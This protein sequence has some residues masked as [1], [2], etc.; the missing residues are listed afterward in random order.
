[1]LRLQLI[2]GMNVW[3]DDQ[4]AE[5]PVSRRAWAL[6]AWLAL[7]PGL[8]ARATVAATFWPDVLDSSARASLRSALWSLRQSLGERS[9]DYLHLSRENLGLKH[10]AQIWVDT[11]AV[12]ELEAAGR[13]ADAVE[14]GYG[15]LLA[16]FDDEWVIEARDAYRPK[17]TGLL[18]ILASRAEEGGNRATAV[19]LTRRQI[20]LDPM[21]EEPL[22]RLMR[23]LAASGDRAAAMTAYNRFRNKL[24]RE[25]RIVPSPE[26]RLLAD[27]LQ[28]R[29]AEIREPVKAAPYD[30]PLIGR[31]HEYAKL[32]AA[33]QDARG[34]KSVVATIS[35]EPGIGK[36]RLATELLNLARADGAMVAG[37][38]AVDLGATAPF[39]MWAELIGGLASSLD[40]PPLDSVW[41]SALAPLAPDFESRLGRQPVVASRTSPELERTRLYEATVGMLLWA[42][43]NQPIVLLMEDIHTADVATLDLIGYVCRR[44]ARVP[45]LMILTR[46]PLPHR[47]QVDALEQSLRAQR[48]LTTEIL[49]G[50]LTSEHAAHLVREVA[51]LPDV[52]VDQVVTAAD[53]NALLA[54]EWAAALARGENSPP[55][56]LRAAVR[57][58]LAPLHGDALELALFAAISGRSLDREEVLSLPLRSPQDAMAAAS[59]CSLLTTSRGRVGYRHALLREAAYVDLS[60]PVCERLHGQ[61]G[62]LLAS[63]NP[64]LAAEAARHLR[65]A[66]RD[67][68]AVAQLIR[69]AD[70]ARAVAALPE[71]A[72]ILTEALELEPHN[73]SIMIDLAEVEALRGEESASS[74]LFERALTC[75]TDPTKLAEAWV[76]RA[77]WYGAA[78]C[79]PRNALDAA[80]RAVEVM[81]GNGVDAPELRIEALALWSWAESVAGDVEMADTL[82]QQVHA[83]LGKNR[84]SDA[85]IPAIGHARAFALLRRGK[86][87]ESYPPEIASAEASKRLGRPDL[88]YGAWANA[89]C[90][91]SCAGE[92]ERALEFV[93]RGLA[94]VADRGLDSLEF[95]LL[96]GRSHVLARLGHHDEA[97][98]AADRQRA[99]AE[100]LNSPL[101]LAVVDHDAG[102][103]ALQLGEPVEAARMLGAALDHGATVSRPIARLSRAEALVATGR[104][105]EAEEE[106]RLTA[107]EPVGPGDMPEALVPRLTWLQGLIARGRGDGSLARSRLQ[108]AAAGWRRVL[109]RAATG[110][111]FVATLADFGRPPVVGMVEPARELDR[112]LADLQTLEPAST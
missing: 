52:Q 106:L 42:A 85:M 46:R 32:R 31:R 81:D 36:T 11:R 3:L 86:F 59:D 80:R 108:D 95:H 63:M 12:E 110:D 37:A 10:D 97:R 64:R 78:L 2:G 43:R 66:G 26:T 53:G 90:A 23:R 35:G 71:A 7:H 65:L 1:M 34:G 22:Q 99:I 89:A 79:H 93:D 96:A 54:V 28:S 9:D 112:V 84:A 30:W 20:E 49:L 41:P 57:T 76:R 98:E 58:A 50:P 13:T 33:W 55:Y 94:D 21:A 74:D 24:E 27:D 82:L 73:S 105:D 87:R 111:Q 56:S 77:T 75:L 68:L 6:L 60:D 39:G 18:E 83:V 5:P 61:F 88:G 38:T 104:Y 16:E 109:S 72:A 14:L 29:R 45:L 91:A 47:V 92:F 107:L 69:A 4:V 62:Q 102:L 40:T 17:I 101:L 103:L 19:E 44:L 51:A 15:V 25:L 70:H 100:R 67:D 48:V 8:H